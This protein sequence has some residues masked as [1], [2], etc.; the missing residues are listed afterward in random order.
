MIVVSDSG[1]LI[2]LMKA[3]QLGL[4]N[5]LYGEVLI[6]EAV[7]SELTTNEKYKSEI[8]QIKNSSFIRIVIVRE[9]IAVDV[10]QKVTGL[11]R[12]ESTVRPAK[13]PVK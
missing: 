10:L 9:K 6:P 8:E 12:G 2:S 1:P 13:K 7:F 3:D 5:K 11:D 4:L